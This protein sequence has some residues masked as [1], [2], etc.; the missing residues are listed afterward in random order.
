MVGSV[1]LLYVGMMLEK[2]DCRI[3]RLYSK[4]WIKFKLLKSGSKQL[5]VGRRVMQMLEEGN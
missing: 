5:K 1:G 3:L 4:Q 2:K